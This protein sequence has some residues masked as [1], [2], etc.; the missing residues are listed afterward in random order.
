MISRG[1]WVEIHKIILGPGARAPQAPEDTQKV[2]LELKARGFLLGD[3]RLDEQVEI[4]TLSGRVLSG[5]LSAT[6]PGYAHSF[7]EPIP[8][9]VPVGLELKKLLAERLNGGGMEEG[10]DR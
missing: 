1:T 8:E 9:L 3:A 4:R 6:N 7:G 2:P 5:T 10:A